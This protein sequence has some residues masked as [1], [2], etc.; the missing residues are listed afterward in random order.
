MT[1]AEYRDEIERKCLAVG[2]WR[3]EFAWTADRL[4]RLYGRIDAVEA[5][6]ER[7]GGHAI[8]THV[9]K[10]K[11]KNFVRNPFLVELDVLYDQA[12]TYERELGLTAAALKR[13]NEDALKARKGGGGLEAALKLLEGGA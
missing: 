3:D 5:E 12:L 11:E 13:I 8:V 6:F 9:N 1:E 7:T 2:T 4:A 10:A